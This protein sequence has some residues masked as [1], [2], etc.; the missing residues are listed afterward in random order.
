MPILHYAKKPDT[1]RIDIVINELIQNGRKWWQ[2]RVIDYGKG[3]DLEKK[4]TL[5][6]RY[7]QGAAGSGLGLSVVSSLIDSYGGQIHVEDRVHGDHTK[8]T[9]FIVTLLA[10]NLL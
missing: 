1:K 4:V 8:G 2:T 5:F 9:I 10:V 3:I 6:Q 7:M